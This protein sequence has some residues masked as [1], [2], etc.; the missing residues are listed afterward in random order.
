MQAHDKF[1]RRIAVVLEPRARI[2]VG[3]A[4]FLPNHMVLDVDVGIAFAKHTGPLPHLVAPGAWGA[5]SG[6][7]AP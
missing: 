3:A 6:M 4:Q 1:I 5:V 7:A 2:V